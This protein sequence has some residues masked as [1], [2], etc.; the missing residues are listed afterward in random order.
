MATENPVRAV[1]W[2][3]DGT[4]IDTRNKNL[5]VTRRIVET[6]TNRPYTDFPALQNISNYE[7]I[8]NHTANWRTFYNESFDL[9]DEQIDESVKLWTE[10]Q[11]DDI[12]VEPLFDGIQ[13]VVISLN[14]YPHGVVSQNDSG[15]IRAQ[16]AAHQI[17]RYFQCIIGYDEVD[18]RQQKPHP[19][20]LLNCIRELVSVDDGIIYYIGDHET[21]MICVEN[22]NRELQQMNSH[23][24]I[25]FIAVA[26]SGQA[27][28]SNYKKEPPNREQHTA[29]ITWNILF[30]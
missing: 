3:Y 20:G 11:K 13:K 2:D 22:A 9:N 16:L 1:I 8:I 5:N 27:R 4:L 18:V 26:Y 14:G 10:F 28:N 29:D 15:I 21:D 24:K 7:N 25:R 6:M 12:S 17:E 23:L 19:E 30:N